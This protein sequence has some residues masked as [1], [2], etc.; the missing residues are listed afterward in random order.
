MLLLLWCPHIHFSKVIWPMQIGVIMVYICICWYFTY[1]SLCEILQKRTHFFHPFLLS[2]FFPL[3]LGSD[4]YLRNVTPEPVVLQSTVLLVV[5]WELSSSLKFPQKTFLSA[6][7]T[8][9]LFMTW[10]AEQG[11]YTFLHPCIYMYTIHIIT[12]VNGTC[13]HHKVW[14]K[15]LRTDVALREKWG[16]LLSPHNHLHKDIFL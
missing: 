15:Y 14:S 7:K 3:F 9:A 5:S 2:N 16:F 10:T 1:Q 11:I 13:V 6:R 12:P 4:I 8:V